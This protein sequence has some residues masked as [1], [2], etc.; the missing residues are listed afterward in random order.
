M[1]KSGSWILAAL[2]ALCVS[3]AASAQRRVTG[4]V[5]AI[6]GE[7]VS[8]ASVSVQGTTI[9]GYTAED[10]RFTLN[11][12]P[13]GAQVLVVRRI[14]YHR[15]TAPLPATQDQID[16]R[17]ERDVLQLETQVVTGTATTVSSANAANAVAVISS[18]QLNRAP[19][20]TV[21]NALQGKIAGAVVSVNSGAPGGGSQIQLRGVTS[22]NASSSPL[23][24][25]DGV[26]VSNEQI[27]S[28]LNSVTNAGGGITNSQDQMVNR[29]ADLNPNDIETIEVLKGAS[30]GAIYGSKASNGV[31]LITTKR[32]SAGRPSF[33]VTQ[34]VGKFSL[35]HKLG[36]RCFGSAAEILDA[37][38]GAADTL[39]WHNAG[40]ACND[41]EEQFFGGNQLSYE[42]LLS[43]S[44]GSG[45]TSY[46]VGGLAKRDAA[47]QRET[48]YQKQS[49]TANLS[50]VL[51]NRITLRA[52]NQFIHSLTDRGISGNDNSPVVAPVD[53]FSST[54]TWFNLQA[55]LPNGQ[56]VS[57][58]YV[59][60]GANPF[61]DAERIKNPEDVYRYVGSVSSTFAA[62]SSAR[63]TLD[64]TLTGGLDAFQYN[65]RLVSP[66][67]LYF[68][69]L[70]GFPGTIVVNKSNSVYANINASGAHKL[71][72]D[73]LTAT[74]SFGLRQERRQLDEVYNRG[75]NVPAG[76][77]NVALAA[78]QTLTENLTLV[79]DFAYYV[80]EELLA[81]DERLLLTGAV[82]T[83]RSSVNGDDK[84]WYSYPKLAASYRL[85]FL[86]FHTDQIKARLAYGKAGNQPP[87]GY[88]FTEYISGVYGGVIGARPSTVFGNPDIRPE[89]STETE[90]GVD[91]TALNSRISLSATLYR[92]DVADLILAA[93][94]APSTGYTTRLLN[95]GALRNTGTEIELG[96]VPV[97]NDR[98]SWIS[99][100]TF[101]R[102]V[103]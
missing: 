82:N 42:T 43:V 102:N 55:R 69:P 96:L 93:P 23:Y 89:T 99:R 17:L 61:Q 13:A 15:A 20:P 30:A 84:K 62:Y 66:P 72:L 59:G 4:R 25:V 64:F 27:G 31:I 28:G 78:Q 34:R 74:T 39:A 26:I 50:Q 6:T 49:L 92:K 37:G 12:V 90:G 97:Q 67:D 88:K 8:A 53:I 24:V 14:G 1:R 44:G 35:S 91:I 81:L 7:P 45:G 47:I 36:L 18:D 83:E 32:G 103:G 79:K 2:L 58:P 73:P 70:D 71:I 48:Y 33:N 87:Y 95:G 65:S 29:I 68:E 9:G 100:T 56:Y 21:E 16:I 38:Y 54:P 22:V 98:A 3:A 75:Q 52:S 101:A 40:G 60:S 51:T 80:Q 41:F 19:T 94:V 10:G 86:P 77:T 11:N 63:Q 57:D 5:T 46:Y 85:P 76:A